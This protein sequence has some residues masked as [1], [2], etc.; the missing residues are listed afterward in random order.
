M[1]YKDHFQFPLF[2]EM[3]PNIKKSSYLKQTREFLR[4]QAKTLVYRKQCKM[5]ANYLSTQPLW[6]S[7]F[8]QDPYRVDALLTKYCNRRFS[9]S[10]RLNY[11]KKNFEVMNTI[12]GNDLC[13]KLVKHGFISLAE[14]PDNLSLRL[15]INQIDPF[16]GFFSINLQDNQRNISIYD[17]SFTFL[18]EKQLL[19][20]S[21]Q[22]SHHENALD[23]IKQS[24]KSLYGIRP[25]YMLVNCFKLM[26]QH[27]QCELL[28]ISHKQ[29]AK[30]RF[31]DHSR[32]LFNYD[33][34]WQSN[35]GRL[36]NHYWHLPLS[37]EIKSMEQIASK[38]R[39]LYRKRYAMLDD[40]E[41]Q[42]KNNLT[43]LA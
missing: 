42:V 6:R 40:V 38:K 37:I 36:I 26:C 16:E 15:N 19:V 31:N 41:Q 13:E 20:A 2:K 17:A 23:L 3:Y 4:Y 27:W 24:T 34:F 35:S 32:L 9:A 14:L 5:L 28:A 1:D 33:V 7:I 18:N 11:I 12:L 21:M 25:M 39:A 29:Q 10:Q 8:E 30:Y 43:S 22:G